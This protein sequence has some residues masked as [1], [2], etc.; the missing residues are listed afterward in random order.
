MASDASCRAIPCFSRDA[1][2]YVHMTAPSETSETWV[3]ELTF[4]ARLALVRQRMGW[5]VKEAARACGLPAQSWRGWELQG[6]APHNFVTVALQIATATGVDLDWLVY[7]PAGKR[8]PLTSTKNGIG[9]RIIA[10]PVQHIDESGPLIP[11]P[12]RPVRRTRPIIQQVQA[13]G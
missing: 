13:V 7:G 1:A 10:R 11:N 8:A 12:R 5:N 2:Y 9:P 4:G 3:P 6:R